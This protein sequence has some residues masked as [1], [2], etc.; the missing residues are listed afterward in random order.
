M[1]KDPIANKYQID[2]VI[3][4][5]AFGYVFKGH[6]LKT[7]EQ[8]AVKMDAVKDC[9]TIPHETKILNYLA[10]YN[11]KGVPKIYW[12]G[13]WQEMPCLVMTLYEC[14]LFD[15]MT[16]KVIDTHI[17]HPLF[18]KIMAVMHHVHQKFV[19]HRD[20]KPQNFMIRKGEIFLIDFG[21]ATFLVNGEGQH[22]P[23]EP[24]TTIT[25]TIKFISLRV[26]E[27]HRYARRDD[28]FSIGYMYLYMLKGNALWE[29]ENTHNEGA[30]ACIQIS[31][32]LNQKRV[33]NKQFDNLV[34]ICGLEP[35]TH[36]FKY[37]HNIYSLKYAETTNYK[38]VFED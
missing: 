19:L 2:K 1:S 22:F 38:F 18:E 29:P 32:P 28:L 7:G 26:L 9:I 21:L 4:K 27:G 10:S 13:V 8:I 25:G 35:H 12:Y 34:K 11:T 36:I 14:S 37:L 31:H 3:S 16:H 24:Q 23:D 30:N 20:I 17:L 33:F 5:G 6:H 15:Y